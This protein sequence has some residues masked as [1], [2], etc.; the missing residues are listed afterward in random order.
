[1]KKITYTFKAI[2]VFIALTIIFT[3]CSKEP[4]APTD[5]RKGK[6]HEDPA[7]VE[8][9]IRKGHLH[10]KM[11]H[12]DP[13]SAINPVQKFFFELDNVSKN[14]VRKNE[15]GKILTESDPVLMIENSGKTVYA[16]EIIYYNHKG[17]RMNSEFT[18]SEMLPIH[19]HF[20]E[21]NSYIN[22]KNNE[23]V[24]QTDDL[25]SYEYRDTDPED[26]MINQFI[27]PTNSPR[28]S[29]LTD[30]PL[31]L[32][33]YFS[34]KKAYVKF[35]LQI[36][37]FHVTKG[38][39]YINDIKSKGFY[40]FNKVGDELEARSSTDF[41]QKVPIYIFTTL[42][43]GSEAET[44][45]YYSDIA[46]QYNITEEEAKRLIKEEKRNQE[47]ESFWM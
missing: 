43:D 14:W 2:F 25:W 46:R 12:A 22:T 34:P 36:T 27:D 3:A 40:P 28:R 38:T 13:I 37:L 29:A 45:R 1:M 31:G 47:N 39:K 33:G 26:I 6:G 9:I 5:E 35:N 11:F 21:V 15:S 20:F 44:M 42:P 32:K 16:L 7:K 8:F 18:T 4:I 23:T 10:D 41:S 19:Q 17:E 30:N 24:T